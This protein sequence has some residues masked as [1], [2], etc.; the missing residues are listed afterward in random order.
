VTNDRDDDANA[1]PEDRCRGEL[2]THET[3]LRAT[4]PNW[5]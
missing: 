5:L 4:D 3:W 2:E 1:E